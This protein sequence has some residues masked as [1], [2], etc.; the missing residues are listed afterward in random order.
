MLDCKLTFKI[1]IHD[2]YP[3]QSM[4]LHANAMNYSLVHQVPLEVGM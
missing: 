4:E 2:E 1:G 3:W